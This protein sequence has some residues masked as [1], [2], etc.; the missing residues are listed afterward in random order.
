MDYIF[1]YDVM[2]EK[3]DFNVGIIWRIN[4]QV[5]DISQISFR[6]M[7]NRVLQLLAMKVGKNSIFIDFL[8]IRSLR[9]PEIIV[10]HTID[11]IKVSHRLMKRCSTSLAI[12]E[13]QIK[14]TLRY[15]LTP[16]R[17]AIVNKSTNECWWGCGEEE[18]LVH[19]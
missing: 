4:I 16:V 19:C 18:I 1:F 12:R 8:P 2:F 5:F 9:Y 15:H 7:G 17:I 14:N 13:M 10:Y 11:F 6:F 3:N